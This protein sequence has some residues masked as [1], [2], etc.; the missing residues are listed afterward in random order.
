MLTV[1]KGSTSKVRMALA[2][3]EQGHDLTRACQEQMQS[4]LLCFGGQLPISSSNK[5]RAPAAQVLKVKLFRMRLCLRSV[6]SK[7][8]L[9]RE[10][11]K[12]VQSKEAQKAAPS[13]TG[14][15]KQGEERV[16]VVGA[17]SSL[18]A[19]CVH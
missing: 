19:L 14:N 1:M 2:Q 11:N 10:A 4:L 6:L 12:S 9:E 3:Q 15:C 5:V 13:S 7:E 18:P 17:E 8:N 16:W